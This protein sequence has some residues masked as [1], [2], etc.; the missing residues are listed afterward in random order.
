MKLIITKTNFKKGLNIIERLTGKNLTLP[1]LNNILLKAE[2]NSLILK[3]TDLEIGAEYQT[4]A[5]VEQ[6]GSIAVPARTLSNLVNFLPD[7][8]IKIE[9]DKKNNTLILSGKENKS[10]IKGLNAD[11]FPIIPQVK[12][13][14]DFMEL[15][16]IPFLNGISKVLNF[17]SISQTHPELSG[18]YFNFQKDKLELVSTDSFRLAKKD[19]YFQDKKENNYSFILPQ[20]AVRESS[21]I[22]SEIIEQTDNPK[23]RIYFEPNQI[24]I[25]FLLED[26]SFPNFK[27]TSR[28][29]EGDY[30][31]YKEII[32][33]SFKTK[34]SL[35]KENL[36]N[37]IKATSLFSGNVNK[38]DID[39]DPSK[40]MV[41]FFAQNIDL[42]ESKSSMKGEIEGEKNKISFNFKY[43]IDGISNL[44]GSNVII[45]LNGEDGPAL[46]KSLEDKDY[47]YILMPIK[48]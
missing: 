25:D 8:N 27:L 43:L 2:K 1:I 36:L 20:K 14:K 35:N 5:K 48:V 32:P 28:L 11:D 13:K 12:N 6:E 42:G 45:E 46:L 22:I 16:G 39:V 10:K 9:L 38:I 41:N 15:N 31:N 3:S 44:E 4:I 24:F 47:L 30:P 26:L 17:C 21:N 18:V 34:I 7:E 29:I 23:V 33:E 40:K 37:Q 19:I